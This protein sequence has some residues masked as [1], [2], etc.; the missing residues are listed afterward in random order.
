[1]ASVIRVCTMAWDA[2][3]RIV[4]SDS[5]V[6]VVCVCY[7]MMPI[8][9]VPIVV[10]TAIY[11][12]A[13][14]IIVACGRPPKPTVKIKATRVTYCIVNAAC[15]GAGTIYT[16]TICSMVNSV[17]YTLAVSVALVGFGQVA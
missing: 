16:I 5:R 17:N 15:V 12:G 1:M 10:I 9:V 14:D 7:V 6:V 13:P 11:A 3:C 8:I 2:A 4:G